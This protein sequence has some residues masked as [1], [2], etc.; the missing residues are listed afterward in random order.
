MFHEAAMCRVIH[1]LKWKSEKSGPVVHLSRRFL[2]LYTAKHCF[3]KIIFIATHR[4]TFD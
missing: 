3:W 4:D 1:S 2:V